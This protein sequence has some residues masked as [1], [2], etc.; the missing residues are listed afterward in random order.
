MAGYFFTSTHAWFSAY[1]Y[2]ASFRH[3]FYSLAWID[4]FTVR[5]PN[6]IDYSLASAH[7]AIFSHRPRFDEYVLC[8]DVSQRGTL[9]VRRKT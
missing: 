3:S 6:R 7:A 9:D 8:Y 5:F 2:A 1:Y 4:V